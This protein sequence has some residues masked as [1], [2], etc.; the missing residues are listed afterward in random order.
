MANK[1]M[2]CR[3]TDTIHQ[4]IDTLF[5]PYD[6]DK[7]RQASCEVKIGSIATPLVFMMI[8]GSALYLSFSAMNGLVATSWNGIGKSIGKGA[9]SV[10]LSFVLLAF[11][12]IFVASAYIAGKNVATIIGESPTPSFEPGNSAS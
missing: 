7:L 9:L 10:I 12:A 11:V 6:D 8:A 4:I 5:P 1:K 3:D 2:S